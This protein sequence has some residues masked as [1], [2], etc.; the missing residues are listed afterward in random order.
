MTRRPT[1][2]VS[3][4][5]AHRR[6]RAAPFPA[7]SRAV[8]RSP[9]SARQ[10]GISFSPRRPSPSPSASADHAVPAPLRARAT[11]EQPSPPRCSSSRHTQ[12][13]QPRPPPH[14]YKAMPAPSPRGAP[15]P[16]R[17]GGAK[18]VAALQ[19]ERPSTSS[20]RTESGGH[21]RHSSARTESALEAAL[22]TL[23]FCCR[24]RASA[25]RRGT[26]GKTAP[27]SPSPTASARPR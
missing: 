13:P 7:T 26:R 12:S 23:R 18:R 10:A 8:R 17:P 16:V 20:G 6:P 27:A 14:A 25:A 21:P 24:R 9:A 11:I 4:H 1:I 15:P 2:R 5:T 19:A 3:L 22:K